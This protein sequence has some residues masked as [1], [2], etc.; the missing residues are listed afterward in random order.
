[1]CKQLRDAV[2]V[3]KWATTKQMSKEEEWRM[4]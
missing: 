2:A 3:A 4:Q 1:V